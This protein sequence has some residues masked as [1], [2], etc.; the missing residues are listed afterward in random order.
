M[1]IKEEVRGRLQF[2]KVTTVYASPETNNN[3]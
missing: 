3:V 1:A 2:Y